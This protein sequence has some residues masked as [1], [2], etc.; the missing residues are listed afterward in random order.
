MHLLS[1]AK[2]RLCGLAAALLASSLNLTGAV[3]APISVL[4]VGNSFTY[5]DAAGGPDLVRPYKP[6]TVT[7]LNHQGIGGVP[8]LFK[9]FTL[10]KGLDYNVSLETNP[11]IGLDWHYNNR[12]ALINQPWDHVVLQSF[13]T[14]DA[15]HPGNPAS[16]IQ[17]SGLLAN[18]LFAQNPNVDI[19]L[20]ATW[21][22]ADQTYLP[23]GA[24]YGQSV[25]AMEQSVRAGY[26]AAAAANVHI[27]D[28][29]Q[30]GQAWARTWET[31][32]ADPNP[33]DGITPGQ[34]NMW[35]PEGYHASVFGYYMEALMFFGDLTGLDP[36]SIGYDQVA[37]DLGISAI[38]ALALQTLA[39]QT[40]LG[41][42][43]P[44]TFALLF[45]GVAGLALA[46]RRKRANG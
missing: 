12:L 28:V 3:A 9:A 46:R 35:A 41:V 39:S 6:N 45:V 1:L 43:E 7:D 14:L 13:S 26:N 18:L 30:T 25:Y 4:F 11:G 19:H 33:Y 16:L 44:E 2:P 37:R 8:S 22:R 27:D 24:W 15:A 5:G 42:P 38:Q 20:D 36:L 17:Y 31:G 40:L 10:E 21:T 34:I 23:T 32:L 29:I